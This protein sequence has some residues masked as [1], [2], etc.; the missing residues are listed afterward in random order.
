MSA[1]IRE[2]MEREVVQMGEAAGEKVA[3]PALVQD[4]E[5]V[6]VFSQS[7][8]QAVEEGPGARPGL[9]Q[10]S[11]SPEV[12]EEML[13]LIALIREANVASH[14]K[15]AGVPHARLIKVLRELRAAARW[16]A[17]N[18]PEAAAQVEGLRKSHRGARRPA[19]VAIAIAEYLVLAR[20]H[21]PRLRALGAWRAPIIEEA[22][23]LLR[24]HRDGLA[25]PPDPQQVRRQALGALLRRRMRL[26]LEAVDYAFRDHP[27]IAWA[28]RSE[29]MQRQIAASA[30]ARRRKGAT[31]PA[32]PAAEPVV[33]PEDDD[34]P[35]APV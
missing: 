26:A 30:R 10:V 28:A 20:E 22:E 5:H 23:A 34:T 27:A 21:E 18:T 24:S 4:A 13:V 29:R 1:E 33:T 2:R 11:L 12:P 17:T 6:A 16:L 9:A 31:K 8:M 32:E 14:R 19:D 15:T 3:G 35:F 25:A 7:H